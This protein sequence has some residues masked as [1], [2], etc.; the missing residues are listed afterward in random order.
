LPQISSSI[1]CVGSYYSPPHIA[2]VINIP[3]YDHPDI[4]TVTFADGSI[5]E[6]SDQ[7]NILEALPNL[8]QPSSHPILP[9][10]IQD[11]VNA[12]LFLTDMSKPHHGKLHCTTDD[13]WFFSPGVS[14]DI[15][16]RISLSN[17][18]ENCHTLLDSP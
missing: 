7:S 4:Y 16:K 18:E 11:G 14:T 8:Q 12:T 2:K 5:S 6:Y 10:W 3:T 9:T 15:T 17:F 1:K 13:H